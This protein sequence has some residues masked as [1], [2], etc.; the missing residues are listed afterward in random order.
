M[1]VY[2]LRRRKYVRNIIV[3][4]VFKKAYY[5]Y[6]KNIRV[7]GTNVTSRLSALYNRKPTT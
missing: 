2:V 1:C 6:K 7:L 4:E 3:A 5:K